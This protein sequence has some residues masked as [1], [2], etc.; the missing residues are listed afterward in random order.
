MEIY[1]KKSLLICIIISVLAVASILSV[2]WKSSLAKERPTKPY[3]PKLEFAISLLNLLQKNKPN[4]N[5]FYS[6][7]SVYQALLLT[8]FGAGGKTEKELENVLGLM[9]WAKNKTD[10]ENAYKLEKGDQSKPFQNESLEFI[11]IDKLYFSDRVN[12][13]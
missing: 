5:I 12:I 6:P 11:S 10:I 13:K 3:Y 2:S 4:E 9:K 1:K 7:H 8:Y